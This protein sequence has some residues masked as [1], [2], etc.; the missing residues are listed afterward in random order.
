M[1]N[2]RLRVEVSQK[3]LVDAGLLALLA[4]TIGIITVAYIS[5]EQNFHWWI[6]W[7]ARTLDIVTTFRESPSKAIE[8]VQRSLI[9]ERNRLYT[10]PLIPFILVFGSSRLVYETGL[11]LVYLLPFA[12]VM[13]AIATQLIRKHSRTLFWATAFLTL[14]VP[15][16]WIPTFMGIPDTGGAAF[17]GLAAFVYLQDVRL[18]QWWRIPLIGFSLGAAVLM[19]RPFVYADVAFLSALS[20]QALVFFI[21]EVRKQPSEEAKEK[22]TQSLIALI[23][24]RLRP[25]KRN[26]IAWRNLL[27]ACVRIAL[28]A[29]TALAT[30]GIVAPHFT[31]TALT[32]DYRTLYTSWSLPFSDISNLYAS[33]YGWGTWLVVVLGFS[34][35]IMTRALPLPAVSFIGFSGVLSLFVWLVLLRYGNVFYSLQVTPLVIIGV[36]ALIWT[37]WIRLRGKV[38][39]LMLGVVGC[40]LVANFIVG[41]TPIG[42]MSR[43]FHPLFALNMPPLVRTDYGEVVR[44]VN[45]LRQLTPNG[46]PIFV[47]GYQRL[48]LTSS[49]LSSAEYLLYP[50]EERS[51]NI[52]TSPEVDSRDF[53]PLEK[54]LEAQYVVVPSR[55]PDYSSDPTQLAAVGEWLPNKEYGVVNVVFDAFTQNWEFA[56]DFKRLPIQFNFEKGVVVS[57]YQRLR[58]TSL[59]TAVRTLDTM[60]Q[61]IGQRPG[62][63][64]NW[65]I[66]SQWVYN[67]KVKASS[68]NTYEVVSFRRDRLWGEDE[69]AYSILESPLLAKELGLRPLD[70]RQTVATSG[71]S[72]SSALEQG[73]ENLS[74][75]A[76]PK[77]SLVKALRSQGLGQP[78]SS[79]GLQQPSADRTQ[80]IGTSLLYLGAVPDQAQ[81]TG[82]IAYIDQD[83]VGSSLRVAMLNSEGQ[84]VSSSESA[85]KHNPKKVTHFELSAHGQNS[86]YLL[87]N[88]LNYDRHDLVNSCTLQINPL[89]VSAQN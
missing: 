21:V 77:V 18:K 83:C 8:L 55:L 84:I 33:F 67:T 89:K 3:L 75:L 12:L 30:L 35:S 31:Y 25:R 82:A 74:P 24:G 71:A 1:P 40:Y 80:Q 64:G 14:L 10:L 66:L 88:I 61:Q 52:L 41:L 23:F 13:G 16:S 20:L 51:L 34:A 54:L 9:G 45:T 2:S 62:S 17:V 47:V 70:D 79:V 38:R 59:A 57:I 76:L 48:Q 44:L 68:N 50:G 72:A 56:R 28:I 65:I 39:S 73:L 85:Y 4:L 60:Q 63:Q 7:Y 49:M 32:T 87:F 11:A 29:A 58:P 42:T 46:E 5:R 15:V 78:N 69:K 81:V 22:Q 19:R 53:Y 43:V 26:A 27:F 36:V 86:A 6:D 37:T